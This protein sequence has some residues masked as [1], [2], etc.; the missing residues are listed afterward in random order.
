VEEAA[1]WTDEFRRRWP[2][3]MEGTSVVIAVLREQPEEARRL[4]SESAWGLG[5]AAAPIRAMAEQAI[6]SQEQV[7]RRPG[8]AGPRLEL[9]DAYAD[10]ALNTA[11]AV[12]RPWWT[13]QKEHLGWLHGFIIQSVAALGQMAVESYQE[14][15]LLSPDDPTAKHRMACILSAMGGNQEAAELL[16]GLSEPPLDR[17]GKPIP[18]AFMRSESRR[19]REQERHPFASLEAFREELLEA[20]SRRPQ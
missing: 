4:L 17:A 9:A 18:M 8:E 3:E 10:M 5:D 13:T 2:L 1:E 6:A 20:A 16:E 11:D 19:L 12:F 7:A 14:A 15:L